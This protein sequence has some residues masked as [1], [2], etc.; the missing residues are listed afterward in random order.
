[1]AC[2]YNEKVQR[3]PVPF[4]VLLVLFG[5]TLYA[6]S[7]MAKW[8]GLPVELVI[9]LDLMLTLL[10]LVGGYKAVRA[11]QGYYKYAIIEGEL[12]IHK[13]SGDQNRLVER[14]KLSEVEYLGEDTGRKSSLLRLTNN[15]SASL[16][17]CGHLCIYRQDGMKRH[18]YF[19]PSGCLM[20]KIQ[21]SL[22]QYQT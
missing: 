16:F 3:K 21:S 2:F 13:V 6:G 19:S 18:L 17:R 5:L 8:A 7:A 20:A 11:T 14:V 4:A 22:R 10:F 15:H 12:L 9:L 1:M